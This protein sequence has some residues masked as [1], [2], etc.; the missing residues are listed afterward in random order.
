MEDAESW[1]DC[2]NTVIILQQR[3]R[4]DRARR[5]ATANCLTGAG[6]RRSLREPLLKGVPG[7]VTGRI[8]GGHTFPFVRRDGSNIIRRSTASSASPRIPQARFGATTT[9]S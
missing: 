3:R 5:D 9:T 1:M 6:R 8:P 4:P 7:G 2:K